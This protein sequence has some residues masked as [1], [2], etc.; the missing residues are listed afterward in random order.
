MLDKKAKW[1]TPTWGNILV[2]NSGGRAMSIMCDDCINAHKNPIYAVEWEVNE[3]GISGENYY[4]CV[5]YTKIE[6]LE[7]VPE[8]TEKQ[9]RESG[10]IQPMRP[11][12][13][14]S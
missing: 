4:T 12:A 3:D 2:K 14:G 9:I 10:G 11:P 8:I 13:Y 5:Q 7:D 6:E 1:E